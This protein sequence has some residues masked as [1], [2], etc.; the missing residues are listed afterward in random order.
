M[1]KAQYRLL[2]LANRET[3]DI[4][5]AARRLK[6]TVAGISNT[7]TALRTM[8]WVKDWKLWQ[9]PIE[10][11]DKGRNSMQRARSAARFNVQ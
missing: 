2:S 5:K 6:T 8:G 7:R 10:I 1:T 3:V 4:H 11:T 9:G